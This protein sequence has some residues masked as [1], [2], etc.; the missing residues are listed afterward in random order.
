MSVRPKFLPTGLRFELGAEDSECYKKLAAGQAKFTDA[1]K[2]FRKRG[3][4]AGAE[5][6]R[7][8]TALENDPSTRM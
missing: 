1:M 4:K 6:R 5:G 7:V 3:K 2:L 8:V